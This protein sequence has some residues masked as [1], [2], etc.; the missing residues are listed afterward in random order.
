MLSRPYTFEIVEYYGPS[1]KDEI[2]TVLKPICQHT[3]RVQKEFQRLSLCDPD[4]CPTDSKII[5]PI[6]KSSSLHMYHHSGLT[7]N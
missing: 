2:Y 3:D 4:F 6:L 5:Q 7:N 1:F